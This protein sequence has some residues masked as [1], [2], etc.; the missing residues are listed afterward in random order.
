MHKTRLIVAPNTK[1]KGGN[2]Q[3]YL[4]KAHEPTLEMKLP[5]VKLNVHM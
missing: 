3:S 5:N 4:Y 2:H 1:R